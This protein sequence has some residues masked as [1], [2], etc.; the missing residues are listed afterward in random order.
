[1]SNIRVA[2]SGLISL[3]VGII[4]TITGLIFTLIVTRTLTIDEYGAWGLIGGLIVYVMVLDPIVTYWT[5]RE[6]ARGE[7][8][9]K[10]ALVTHGVFSLIGLGLYVIIAFF[11]A[12]E[13]VVSFDVLILGAMLIPVMFVNRV[14]TALNL[15]WKP[16]ASSYGIIAFELCKIPLALLLVYHLNLGLEGA[17]IATMISYVAS[18]IVLGI[19][20]RS[21][22]HV[23]F[24][25]IYVKKWTKLFWIPLYRKG[26]SVVFSFDVAIFAIITDSVF[27]IALFTV[28]LAVSILVGHAGLIAQAIYPKLLSGGSKEH[29]NESLIRFFYFGFPLA[30]ISIAFARPALFALNPAYEIAVVVVMIMTLR[31][32]IYVLSNIFQAALH[33]TETIDSFEN[34][35]FKDFIKSKLFTLPT[36]LL[37]Q[38]GLYVIIL[39]IVLYLTTDTSSQ[40]ELVMYWSII[41]LV[42]QIPFTL[43]FFRMLKTSFTV[44]IDVKVTIKYLIS[45]ILVFIGVYFLMENFLI[46]QESIF[47]FLPNLILYICLGIAMYALITFIID[48]RTR[49]LAKSII[50]ELS[51][52]N[53]SLD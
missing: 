16:Q 51:K 39:A 28:S 18:I 43:Y 38:Y 32:F 8:S 34:P 2:Y 23:K 47:D 45:S 46:Y 4:S 14:L 30:A 20:S 17:I 41:S 49:N 7:D 25:K 11:V 24:Q 42:I 19:N 35:K 48:I 27:G 52:N 1:M 21:K 26:Q 36:I 22:L 31:T 53:K 29:L 3:L 40:L 37:I 13:T 10:T 5:T 9:G 15:G 12:N 44:S 33:G 50:T 6:I